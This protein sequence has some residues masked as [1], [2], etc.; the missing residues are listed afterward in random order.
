[1]VWFQQTNRE[2]GR[3]RRNIRTGRALPANRSSVA[4]P[5]GNRNMRISTAYFAGA[6]TVIA[7]IVGGVGGGLLIADM[8]AP[9]SPKGT[10]MT[11]L[12]RR[13]SSDPIQ[14]TA[15][16]S[17]PAP[18]QPPA[19]DAAAAT[20]PAPNQAPTESVKSASTG[21]PPTDTATA[22]QPAAQVSQPAPPAVQ[23]VAREQTAAS[24]EAV[25][26]P[27]NEARNEPRDVEAKRAVEKRRAERRQQWADRRRYQQRQEQ[28][29]Q[30]VEETVREETG[31]RRVFAAEPVRG[32]MPRIRLF[33][34]E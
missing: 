23:P 19:S 17:Q 29:L 7:A 14:V 26:K 5:K 12:E 31:P 1:L 25:A 8:I 20:V 15:T 33:G 16:P 13:M 3:R 6:G 27:R 2:R 9:K 18:S 32:E 24:D 22:P 34:E 30:S 28:E 4:R 21:S 10:E 11:R